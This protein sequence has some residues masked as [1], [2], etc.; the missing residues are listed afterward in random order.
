[1]LLY[2]VRADEVE[3]EQFFLQDSRLLVAAALRTLNLRLSIATT[4]ALAK[5]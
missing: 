4:I 3:Q 5:T 1:L 2:P